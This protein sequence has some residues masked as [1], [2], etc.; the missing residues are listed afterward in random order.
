MQNND[1][2]RV[3]AHAYDHSYTQ[4]YM[5]GR[6]KCNVSI[7]TSQLGGQQGGDLVALVTP[8][9]GCSGVSALATMEMT[10][11]LTSM[12]AAWNRY[13]TVTTQAGVS[14]TAT[15][16]GKGLGAVQVWSDGA[17]SSGKAS[18]LSTSNHLLRALSKP[19]AF[20]TGKQRTVSEVSAIIS[21]ARSKELGTYAKYGD[22]ATAKEMS[23]VAMMWNVLYSLEIPGTFAP[24]S[25]GWGRPWVIFDWDNIFGA[26]Q[27][28]L[29][30]KELAYSQLTAVIKTK[31]A[32][33]MVPNF[34]Q[35][36]SISYDRTEPPIGS[37]V[38]HETFKRWQEPW[39][40]ELLFDDCYDWTQWFFRRRQD[41]PLGLIVLGSDKIADTTDS[42]NMQAARFE[43]GLDNSPMYDG[44]VRWRHTFS[45]CRAFPSLTR[46][47][48]LCCSSIHS[49]RRCSRATCTFT[50]WAWRRCSRWSCSRWR[51]S[52]SPPSRRRAPPSTPRS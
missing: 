49:T 29:D 50:T 8:V 39:F 7:E 44:T 3:G 25:R 12:C 45:I 2:V 10:D 1:L 30:A 23:Q 27:F 40:V 52:A 33:G 31:T 48:S 19:V 46:T 37:K 5:Q 18:G 14:M 15:P 9:S 34:W 43:S 17:A 41:A 6:S 21:S 24:V 13:G 20:S 51:T 35:P 32:H 11:N 26:Y 38:L 16:N 42:P 28:S 36:N 47:A 22:L 4:L